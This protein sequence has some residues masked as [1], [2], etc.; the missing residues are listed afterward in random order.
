MNMCFVIAMTSTKGVSPLKVYYIPKYPR[1]Q[2]ILGS[3]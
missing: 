3:I 1:K 2:S